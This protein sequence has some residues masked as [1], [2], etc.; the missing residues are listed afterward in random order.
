MNID[1]SE[2]SKFLSSDNLQYKKFI[3]YGT[4]N[5]SVEAAKYFII[6]HIKATYNNSIVQYLSYDAS[7]KEELNSEL[8]AK[9]LFDTYKKIL[10]VNNYIYK[11]EILTT[12]T[13]DN[14]LLLLSNIRKKSDAKKITDPN[15]ITISCYTPTPQ[16]IAHYIC[17]YF[18]LPFSLANDIASIV[19]LNYLYLAND[20]KKLLLYSNGDITQESIRKVL[21]EENTFL[22]N[23]L[24]E[25]ILIKDRKA[26]NKILLQASSQGVKQIFIVRQIAKI[27]EN[28]ILIKT[29][30]QQNNASFQNSISSLGIF[31]F[32]KARDNLEKLV[33]SYSILKLK[34][35]LT[36]ILKLEI[37]IKGKFPKAFIMLR[38]KFLKI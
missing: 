16:N 4:D 36:F 12:E 26:I 33:S 27:L 28:A 11:K 1:V 19:P 13:F 24:I 31:A 22:I 20:I 9:S 25:K 10:I 21:D 34:R 15:I 37:K 3:L 8:K 30:I 35:F 5:S 14:F 18:K 32:F 2:L 7:F 29:Y 38:E 17:N 6:E 23:T